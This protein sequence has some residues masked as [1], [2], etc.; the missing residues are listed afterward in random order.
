[1]SSLSALRASL[2]VGSQVPWMV[3]FLNSNARF[4]IWTAT[5]SVFLAFARLRWLNVVFCEAQNGWSATI[6]STRL[7][8]TL[9]L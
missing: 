4:C 6:Y 8:L 3:E 7:T 1:M 2:L 9:A 5:Q